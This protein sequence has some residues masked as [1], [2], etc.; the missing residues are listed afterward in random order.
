MKL[1][2][3]KEETADLAI[4]LSS[5]KLTCDKCNKLFQTQLTQESHVTSIINVVDNKNIYFLTGFLF[6]MLSIQED[7]SQGF[8]ASISALLRMIVAP[9]VT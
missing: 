3:Q 6:V 2:L 4:H 5:L 8:S 7:A 1:L 9:T